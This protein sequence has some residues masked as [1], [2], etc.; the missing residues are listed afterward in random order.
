MPTSQ[1]QPDDVLKSVSPLQEL[2]AYEALW[3]E[4]KTNFKTLAELFRKEPGRL[5]SS[6]VPE[7]I[8]QRCADY[9]LNRFR[10]VGLGRFGVR[11]HGS[12][13]YP[14]KLRDAQFPVEVLYF[15]GL[16]DLV[17]SRSV[18]V[19]GTRKPSDEGKA[20]A[21]K[22]ARALV[23]DDFTVVSGLAE[24][25]DTEAHRAALDAGGRTMAV[26]GT[27]L[28][29]AYP[30]VNRS[31]QDEI[32]RRFLVISQVPLRRWEQQDHRLNRLFFPERNATMSALTEAT[33]IVEASETSGTLIQAKAAL[34]QGRT[35]FILESNF[36]NPSITWPQKFAERGAIRVRDYEDIRKHLGATSH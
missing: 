5:P 36:H 4:R 21:R 27:P 26:I 20:R 29:H 2:G 33:V 22:L 16:W 24:G 34:H 23:A 10:E 14:E 17:F 28:S 25:I 19:V 8:A 7:T 15:A 30:K 35:L 1:T 12:G 18:A 32:A 3:E 11:V 31:L 13:E 9:V 6:F